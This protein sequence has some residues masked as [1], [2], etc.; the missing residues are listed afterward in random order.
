M[1]NEVSLFCLQISPHTMW[2]LGIVLLQL[3][4]HSFLGCPDL[5]LMHTQ[6]SIQQETQKKPMQISGG[7]SPCSSFFFGTLFCKFQQ[8]PPPTPPHPPDPHA[9]EKKK[10]SYL[11][12]LSSIET[13]IIW[14]KFSS[15]CI[16]QKIP[17]GRKQNYH[18]PHLI[19]FPSLF[20]FFTYFVHF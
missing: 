6:L 9:Q 16:A 18:W 5:P 12:L 1:F 14:L 11:W 2:A 3:P 13:V 19:C 17:P 20:F 8:S 15:L 7:F 10:N 4:S